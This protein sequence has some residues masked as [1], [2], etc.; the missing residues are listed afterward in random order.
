MICDLTINSA[1]VDFVMQPIMRFID[2][3]TIQIPC[4]F[5]NELNIY[6]VNL[7]DA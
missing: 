6:A 2:L 1:R 4:S 7:S 5:A 3:V